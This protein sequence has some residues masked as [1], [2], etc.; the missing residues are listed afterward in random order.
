MSKQ[1]VAF[2]LQDDD[3]NLTGIMTVV[4]RKVLHHLQDLP[5]I[6]ATD[7]FL[8]TTK[9]KLVFRPPKK[10]TEPSCITLSM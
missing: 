1:S 4:T 3:S 2:T 9:C 10:T 6:V 8:S 5:E 7:C